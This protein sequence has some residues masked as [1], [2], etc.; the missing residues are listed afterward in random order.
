M[1][2]LFLLLILVVFSFQSAAAGRLYPCRDEEGRI[3]V[4]DRP[5]QLPQGC[6]L[7]GPPPEGGG[8][9]S[10]VPLPDVESPAAHG[11]M[12]AP[13]RVEQK[14]ILLENQWRKR[15]ESLLAAWKT[16]V[17]DVYRAGRSRQRRLARREL[18]RL[19]EQKRALLAEV[20]Q[21]GRSSFLRWM[22]ERLAPVE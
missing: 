3:F 5:Y 12:T 7:L 21:Q 13:S 18:D 2:L 15:A 14:R 11:A 22:E 19:R 6:V 4:T 1:R 20:Q 16:A 10:I 9:L 8:R 17:G